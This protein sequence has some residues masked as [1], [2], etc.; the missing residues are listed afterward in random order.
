MSTPT[1][2]EIGRA[3]LLGR[4]AARAGRSL[5]TNPFPADQRV[6]RYR[7]AIAHASVDTE[8]SLTPQ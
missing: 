6:L 1:D 8:Q 3:Q 7:W 4:A 2:A 5:S